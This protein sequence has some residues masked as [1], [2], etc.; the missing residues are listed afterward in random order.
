MPTLSLPSVQSLFLEMCFG[1]QVLST[2]TGFVVKSKRGPVL[3]TNWHNLSGR[4]PR[5]KQPLSPT[6]GIP[7]SVRIVHN[8]SNALG[9]WVVRTEPLLV[10]GKHCWTEHPRLGDKADVVALPLTQL[11]DVQLYPY[12]LASS[13]GLLIA[14]AE[15]VSVVGFPFGL[16]GGGSLAIWATGFIATEPDVDYDGL[17]VFL[18]D[19]RARPGQSGSAVIAHRAGGAVPMADGGSAMFGGPITQFLGVYSGR[20]NEQSDLG[21]VW[22]ARGVAELVDAI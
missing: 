12:T 16:R 7:D 11:H 9:S 8:R 18:V 19:C 1:E 13:T 21:I 6:A 4:D 15:P 22:N 14:P 5:T 10:E 17:P 3:V 20:I 2:G